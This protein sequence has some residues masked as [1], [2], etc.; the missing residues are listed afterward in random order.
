MKDIIFYF[1]KSGM[2]I[3]VFS[4]IY[5]LLLRRETFYKF[6]RFFL[7]FGLVVSFILPFCVYKYT[8]KLDITSFITPVAT[9]EE[10]ITDPGF[11]I[12]PWIILIAL[13]IAGALFLLFRHLRGAVKLRNLI[14]RNGFSKR[15]K[16]KIVYAQDVDATFS[17][18]NYIFIDSSL[19]ISEI[20]RKMIYEHECAHINQ[21][22]WVDLMIIHI[23]CIFQWFNPF[24]WIYLNSIKQ[25][26]EFLADQEV[27]KNG[28]SPAIYRA[29]LINYTLKTPVFA[30]ANA[31]AQ[32]N[33]FKRID[34]MKKEDSNPKK[35][36]V[37][38]LLVPALV[39]FLW[40]FAEPEYVF[41]SNKKA[42]QMNLDFTINTEFDD[43]VKD[44]VKSVSK[45]IVLKSDVKGEDS[46]IS[47]KVSDEINDTI[48]DNV[49]VVGYGVQKKDM[50]SK[51]YSTLRF[52]LNDTLPLTGKVS[53]IQVRSFSLND[54]NGERP[55]FIIDGK[56]IDE[57]CINKLDPKEIESLEV[58][59]DKSSLKI[60]GTKGQNGV[61]LVTTKRNNLS[62]D[63]LSVF[64]PKSKD[65]SPEEIKESQDVNFKA[66][67]M[68]RS[69]SISKQPLIVIDG[70]ASEK[71]IEDV[72][73]EDIESMSILK[74]ASASN[75]YGEKGKHGV[76]VITT[77]KVSKK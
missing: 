37:V 69:L 48:K 3:G 10:V 2:W 28:N 66:T 8:I 43:V 4:M 42:Q 25:N 6:N 45:V 71:G 11:V 51:K 19:S 46:S 29:A 50:D 68:L 31:F 33:K 38:L 59:K 17:I 72:N 55:L 15:S 23:V 26:H 30:F 52:Q 74:D 12:S 20:E 54:N 61:I 34:M 70:V 73:P 9:N 40:F 63:Q 36:W 1:L 75:I 18:F 60:Y 22:H 44:S 32:Y 62:P 49:I 39:A 24:V 65:E 57:S 67:T 5:W 47:E 76:I 14:V 41:A 21:Y 58:L 53:Q 64:A 16:T 35:K 56:E 13:H 77:K 7:L 27:L